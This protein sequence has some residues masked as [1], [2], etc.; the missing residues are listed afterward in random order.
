M[1]TIENKV[2]LITGAGQGIGKAI[3]LKLAKDGAAIA[4][5]DLN[6]EKMNSVAEEVR[7]LGRKAITIKADIS[8]QSELFAAVDRTE[9]ELGGFE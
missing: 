9:R 1:E 2:A 7:Q 3:A 4:I 6:E 8:K 5:L